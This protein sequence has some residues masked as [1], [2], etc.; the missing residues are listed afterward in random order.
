MVRDGLKVVSPT[1]QFSRRKKDV[2]IT[3][4]G[5]LSALITAIDIVEVQKDSDTKESKYLLTL[6]DPFAIEGNCRPEPPKSTLIS[7]DKLPNTT[8]NS[9]IN[10]R[11]TFECGMQW[12]GKGKTSFAKIRKYRFDVSEEQNQSP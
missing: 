11:G 7:L 12:V 9:E 3:V 1:I 10:Y 4:E 8:S 2:K 5:C 6:D